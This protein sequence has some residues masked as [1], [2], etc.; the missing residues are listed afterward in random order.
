MTLE[1]VHKSGVYLQGEQTVKKI[2][3]ISESYH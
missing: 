1:A 3:T 2:L